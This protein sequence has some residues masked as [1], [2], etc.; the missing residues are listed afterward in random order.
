MDVL[1]GSPYRIGTL[2]SGTLLGLVIVVTIIVAHTSI[3]V[4]DGNGA[5]DPTGIIV[6]CDGAIDS[7]CIAAAFS[8]GSSTAGTASA[9]AAASSPTPSFPVAASSAGTFWTGV[10]LDVVLPTILFVIPAGK[11]K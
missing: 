5:V 6:E 8:C 7:T 4:V 11:S 9:A 2:L 10:G 1:F 3:E